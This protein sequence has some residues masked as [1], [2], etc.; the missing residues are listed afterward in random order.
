M[1]DLLG[2]VVLAHGLITKTLIVSSGLI[3]DST[4]S[5]KGEGCFGLE[6]HEVRTRGFPGELQKGC[7]T[8]SHLDLVTPSNFL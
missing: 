4:Q 6:A 8:W 3:P 1:C 2:F 7:M 5:L